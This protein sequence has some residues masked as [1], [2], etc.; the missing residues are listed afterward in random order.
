LTTFDAGNENAVG[1]QWVPTEGNRVKLDIDWSF[2]GIPS[3]AYVER[4]IPV[5]EPY[6]F[7][8][9]GDK[10]WGGQVGVRKIAFSEGGWRVD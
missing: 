2:A 10:N 7:S 1:W 6:L 5:D 3:I 9:P 8:I 4:T